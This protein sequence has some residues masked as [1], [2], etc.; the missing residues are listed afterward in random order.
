[1]ARDKTD[2]TDRRPVATLATSATRGIP[3]WRD[4]SA[5]A[6]C[7]TWDLDRWRWEFLRRRAD[8]RADFEAA[9][10]ALNTSAL[11]FAHEGAELYELEE[12]FAPWV[13]DWSYSGPIWHPLSLPK[14]DDDGFPVGR[15]EWMEVAFDLSKPLT[16]QLAGAKKELECRQGLL[17]LSVIESVQLAY[18]AEYSGEKEIDIDSIIKKSSII[19]RAPKS[20]T[21]KWPTYIR[22]L[23]ARAAGASYSAISKTLPEYMD[24][25]SPF[26]GRE[27]LRQARAVWF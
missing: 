10:Q 21:Q 27:V 2:K 11:Q 18:G 5:Y 16:P 9:A 6:E 7:K 8:Y 26:A 15:G 14:M 17:N 20:H 25:R 22:A 24:S 4:E 1:M 13:S 23:D 12:F 3:D 19:K